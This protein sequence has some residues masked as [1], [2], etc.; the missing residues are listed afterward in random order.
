MKPSEILQYYP[1]LKERIIS[2]DKWEDPSMIPG[3]Q[4][5][6]LEKRINSLNKENKV[7]YVTYFDPKLQETGY[8]KTIMKE[9]PMYKSKLTVAGATNIEVTETKPNI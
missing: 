6:Y 3:K 5:K 7:V 4:E 8:I 2:E 9:V 1:S